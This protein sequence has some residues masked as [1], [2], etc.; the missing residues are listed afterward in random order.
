MTAYTDT[1]LPPRHD[2]ALPRWLIAALIVLALHVGIGLFIILTR[3][4]DMSGGA[5]EDTVIIDLSPIATAPAQQA[6]PQPE[7]TPEPPP[8]MEKPVAPPTPVPPTPEL[9]P[10]PP[11]AEAVLPPPPPPKPV[12]DKQEK[13]KELEKQKIEHQKQVDRERKERA[14]R[15]R[16][17]AASQASR[18][19][20]AA[21]P[22]PGASSMSA[23]DWRSQVQARVNAAAPSAVN[24]NGE[25]GRAVLAFT[26]TAAGA[27]VGAHISRSSG[28]SLLDREALG[29][30][31]RLGRLPPPPNGATAVAVPVNVGVR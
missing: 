30:A 29:I 5:P 14:E 4:I 24:A 28:S 23:S 22:A 17:L 19:A 2:R 18:A 1:I 31:H 6:A 20:R 3:T 11:Q 13:Q 26:V 12:E 10:A 16:A 25:S 21:G 27:V 15:A 8:A 7:P 9:P